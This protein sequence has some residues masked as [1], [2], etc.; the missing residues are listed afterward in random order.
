MNKM[1]RKLKSKS[2]DTL[3]ESLAAFTIVCIAMVMLANVI[4][5]SATSMK[6]TKEANEKYQQISM[7]YW[8]GAGAKSS[9]STV[10]DFNSFSINVNIDSITIED[11]TFY[12]IHKGNEYEKG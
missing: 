4:V 2:G 3:I 6:K 12:E 7:E 11:E 5:S 9:R 1:I 8:S 10:L